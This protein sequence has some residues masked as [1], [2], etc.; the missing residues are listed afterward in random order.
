VPLG[1]NKEIKLDLYEMV[2]LKN[3]SGLFLRLTIS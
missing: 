2:N 3:K 1:M